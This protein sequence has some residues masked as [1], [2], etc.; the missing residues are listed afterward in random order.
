MEQHVF[1][2]RRV[3]G[4][5]ACMAAGA[6]ALVMG[7]AGPAGATGATGGPEVERGDGWSTSELT[8]RFGGD[9]AEVEVP[10]ESGRY[11][12]DDRGTADGSD[13]AWANVTVEGGRVDW[14]SEGQDI[15]VVQVEGQDESHV[16]TYGGDGHGGRD[17]RGGHDLE[18]PDRGRGGDHGDRG[19]GIRFCWKKRGG[20]HGSTTTTE[21]PHPTTSSTTMPPSTTVP[22][23][24]TTT[25]GPTT[26]EAPTTTTT[27]APPPTEAPTTTLPETGSELP[28]T[29]SSTAPLLAGAGVLLAVGVAAF[30]GRR[31]LQQRA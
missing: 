19:R 10:M 31:H 22:P 14:S 4:G 28:R 3:A 20:G 11:L 9:W 24:S 15:D 12:L 5:V 8:D 1:G 30:L 17:R 6:A 25:E 29:G 26:T 7:L 23:S 21:H 2:R 16:Y 27:E 18:R 13:D